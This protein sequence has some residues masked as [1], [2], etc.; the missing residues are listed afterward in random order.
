MYYLY[1]KGL[2]FFF[3]LLAIQT[4]LGSKP[5][6]ELGIQQKKVS[7]TKL[8]HQTPLQFHKYDLNK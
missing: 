3:K 4:Q 7:S 8:G 1:I 6:I 5:K 2:F